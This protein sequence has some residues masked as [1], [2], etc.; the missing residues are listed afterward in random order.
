[1]IL[2]LVTL[3]FSAL[4]DQ[5]KVSEQDWSQRFQ[6]M[7]LRRSEVGI[8]PL[9]PRERMQ[10]MLGEPPSS[11]QY[12][13]YARE[14]WDSDL[15]F[16]VYVFGM[17]KLEKSPSG[18]GYRVRNFQRLMEEEKDL[19]KAM[20]RLGE[21]AKELHVLYSTLVSTLT[22]DWFD[23]DHLEEMRKNWLDIP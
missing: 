18:Y 7:D 21:L 16:S 22:P 20:I 10:R 3:A 13:L 2:E 5:E 11:D 15:H 6:E 19:T 14:E 4:S 8:P 17:A 12:V 23:V 1:M 9:T